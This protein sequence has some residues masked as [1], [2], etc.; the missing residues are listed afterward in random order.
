VLRKIQASAQFKTL[1]SS[2]AVTVTL[3]NDKARHSS[4]QIMLSERLSLSSSLYPDRSFH[5][6]LLQGGQRV[7]LF[8]FEM[9]TC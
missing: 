8:L 6:T 4:W 2:N 5:Q 1:I 3:S 9:L 7:L